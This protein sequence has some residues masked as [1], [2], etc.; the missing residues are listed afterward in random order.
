MLSDAWRSSIISLVEIER[1]LSEDLKEDF[2]G[3]DSPEALKGS[4]VAIYARVPSHDQ[5]KKD[6]L[7]DRLKRLK[8]T[9]KGEGL[10]ILKCF[11]MLAVD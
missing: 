8:S 2:E 1:V 3:T 7:D 6:D 5:K 4:K 10:H 11:T 9:V